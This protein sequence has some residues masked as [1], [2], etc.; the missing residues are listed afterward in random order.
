[1]DLIDFV[2]N[3]ADEFDETPNEVFTPDTDFKSLEEWDSLMALTVI[4]MVQEKYKKFITGPDLRSV[5]TIREL[6][7]LIDVK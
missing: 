6:S 4:S 3:F 1:M 2:N 7:E 5:K